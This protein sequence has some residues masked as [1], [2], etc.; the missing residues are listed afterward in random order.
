MVYWLMRSIIVVGL[1]WAFVANGCVGSTDKIFTEP[2]ATF[3]SIPDF[4]LPTPVVFQ[5][6]ITES[7][8]VELS[9]TPTYSISVEASKTPPGPPKLDDVGQNQTEEINLVPSPLRAGLNFGWNLFEGSI[10]YTGSPSPSIDYYPPVSE[11]DHQEGCSVTGGYVYRGGSLPDWQGIYLFGD[12][13]TG[14]VWGLFGDL[15]GL[16]QKAL[17]FDD[18]GRIS[19]FG[20]DEFGEIYLVEHSGNLYRLEKNENQ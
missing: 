14:K 5:K 2:T 16:W 18:M 6:L 1:V 11:Y 8:P 17:L 10:P 19:S 12:Y 7:V 13:C 15:N 3:A 20:V 4:Q 9:N